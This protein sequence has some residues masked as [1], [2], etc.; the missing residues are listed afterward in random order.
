MNEV[1]QTE[2][3]NPGGISGCLELLES[4]QL[5]SESGKY[6]KRRNQR[7]IPG[8]KTPHWTQGSQEETR[9]SHMKPLQ[10]QIDGIYSCL[11]TDH[12]RDHQPR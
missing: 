6:R 7:V 5:S 3:G 8:D 9:S 10:G 11:E 12:E 2:S 1:V 4:S